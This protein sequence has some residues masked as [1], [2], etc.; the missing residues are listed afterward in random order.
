MSVVAMACAT[1]AQARGLHPGL[2]STAPSQRAL[3]Q[4]LA[5]TTGLSPSQVTSEDICSAARPGHARCAGQAL[6]LRS[7]HALV[8]PH[9]RRHGTLGRVKPAFI[10]G[11]A[12]PATTSASTPPLPGTP[13]YL[14]QAYDLTYLSQT[15]GVGDTIAIIDPFRNPNAEADLATYR[16]TNGL[17]ACTTSNGC[18]T[19]VNQNGGSTPPSTHDATWAME[20]SLDLDAVSALCPNCRI[21]LVEANSAMSSDLNAAQATAAALGANQIS[22]SWTF[23]VSGGILAGRW[24]FP[25]ISTVA[26]TGDTGYLGTNTDNFPA[27]FSGVTAAGGSSLAPAGGGN[28]R[29]FSEGAWSGA[30]SGCD[31]RVSKPSWQTDNGCTGRAYADLSADA[32]PATGLSFYDS[33]KGGWGVIGGTSLAAPLIAAYYAITGVTASS[34]PRWAYVNSASLNDPISGST[35]TCAASIRYICNAG[36]GYDGPTGVGSISGTAVTGAPGIGGPANGSGSTTSYTQ[37]KRTHG[38]TLEGGIFPNGLE[39]SWWIEYGTDTS[40]GQQTFHTD[41]GSGTSPVAVT[42]YLSH[43]TANTTYHYRL[44]AQNILGTTYGYDYTFATPPSSATDPTAV[45]TAPGAAPS[46]SPTSFDASGSTDSGD[47]ITDYTWDFGDGTIKDAGPSATA[48]HRF[49]SRGTYSVTLIVTNSSGQRDS[50]S[51]TITLD[52]PTASFTAP[53]T[54]APGSQAS[55]DASASSDPLGTITDYRWNFGDGTTDDTATTA[56]D[57]HTYARG[58]Y[59]VTLTITNSFGQT[60]TATH[61]VTVDNRPTAAFTAPSGAQTPGSA[62]SFDAGSSAPGAD[63]TIANYSWNFGDGG[64]DT[65]P[66]PSHTYTTAG[67][68]TVSLTVTDDLGLT[69][70]ITHAVTVD[71]APAASFAANP[72]RGSLAVAFDAG[73]SSDSVGTITNYSWDFGDGSTGTGPTPTHTYATRGT[74]HV[75]LTV[76]NDAGQTDTIEHDVTADIAP[77]AS[78]TAPSGAQQSNTP[79]IFDGTASAPGDGGTIAGYSWDFGDNGTGSGSTPS[80]T[81]TS[82]GTYNVTLTVT[83]DLRVTDTITHA[84]TVDAAPTASFAADPDRGSLAVAFDAG[85]SSD[86]LGTIT[87]YSWDFGDGSTGTGPTP[88]HTYATRDTYTV[89]LTVTNDAGQTDTIEHDVTA[90]IAPTAAF[91][92]SATITTPGSALDFDASGST[93]STGAPVTGYTWHFGDGGTGTGATPSHTYTSSGHYTVS[94]TVTDDLGISSTATTQD[95][96]VDQPSA[97]FTSPSGF[98]APGSAASFDASGSAD[99]EGSITDYRWDFGDGSNGTG[100]NPSHTYTTRGTHPVTLTVTNNYGQTDTSASQSVIVDTPPTAAFSPPAGGQ[101]PHSPVSFDSSASAA[102]SGGR[103]TAYSWDFGDGSTGTGS[104]PSHTYSSP[105]RY[106]VALTVTDELGM[107][108]TTTTHTVTVDAAPIPSFAASPNPA[109]LGPAV[110]FDARGSSDSLGT[111]TAYSWDFGDG[112]T[113]SGATTTHAYQTPGHYTI[114]LTITNDA[115]QTATVNH[116]VTVD[117]APSSSF[118]VS[119]SAARTNAPV[120][121]NAGSSSDTVGTIV[122]YTWNFGDGASAGSL[123]AS[124]TYA[125]PGSYMV[126]LTVTNDAGQTA[127]STQTVTVYAPPSASFSVAPA[128]ALPGAAVNFNAGASS[129]PGGAITGYSWSFGDGATSNGPG[130]SHAYLRPGTYTVTLTVAGSLGL[131]MSTSH[132]VTVNPPPLSARLSARSRQK[133]TTALKSGVGVSVFTNTAAKT[134]FVVAM[135]ASTSKQKRKHGKRIVK[136]KTSTIL[137]SGAFNFAPGTHPASLKLSPAGASKLRTAGKPVVLTVQ[138]TLT[139]VYGRKTTRSVKLTVTR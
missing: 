36:P 45:F 90:D 11:F 69:D 61:L 26:A 20:E 8:R 89:T 124:H 130:A 58:T 27:A 46:T 52:D 78:F 30:S 15:G 76:T 37:S 24:I 17:P 134:S 63:G 117:A 25:G 13:A 28:A 138:M 135:P 121:F 116:P 22:D 128:T 86:S 51:Q 136:Q 5:Q 102:A 97:S 95:V 91:S 44:V 105:G 47:S 93:D 9:A 33:E 81:Y 48:T 104:N 122:A 101:Q 14:Q 114:T 62:L 131:A 23:A 16:A 43:L 1:S 84:V 73:N 110:A 79:L 67:T 39:T 7:S 70:T 88:T 12:A 96:T 42:G 109:T 65:G 103:I 127:T 6:V 35:G 41:I 56:T 34:T 107:P 21:L 118:S 54:V 83:D 66:A 75:T 74:Y 99:P 53:Q 100:S 98:V 2:R 92:P 31:L 123:T 129:D 40:Y 132:T 55:F 38:A 106:T 120:S 10:P 125:S 19:K 32:D 72:D 59:T 133:L 115:G 85:T 111:I 87:N 108:S 50:T 126:A 49:A 57:T 137:R 18:F 139:D 77:T 112:S 3:S 119:P 80:H 113:G 82:A 64:T 4:A 60:A 68:Y 71:A 94:L 29:G